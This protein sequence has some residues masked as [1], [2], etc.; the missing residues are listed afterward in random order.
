MTC[1]PVSE[2]A[3]NSG[4]MQ[5]GVTLEEA[6]EP[7]HAAQLSSLAG[8]V[9]VTHY[10]G[11]NLTHLHR[12]EPNEE[13]HDMNGPFWKRHRSMDND[14]L[15]TALQLPS[16]LRLPS[17]IRDSNVV[18]LN[19]ALHTS[20]IC[21]HQAAIFKAEKYRLP[22]TIIEQSRTRC[23]LAAAEIASVMRLTSHL[24]VAGVSNIPFP[25]LKRPFLM[26]AR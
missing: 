25:S 17:G 9:L 18:F 10:F 3:Y 5:K 16:R 26:V 11:R 4:T 22:K 23:I 12:P 21:L 6:T 14:L 19:F 8:V 1:L 24:D 15:R 13:E 7:Q 20:T 2:E